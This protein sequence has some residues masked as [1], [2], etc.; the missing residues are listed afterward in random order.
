M[1]SG[2]G[3]LLLPPFRMACFISSRVTA[4]SS[5]GICVDGRDG[6]IASIMLCILSPCITNGPYL[7]FK[8]FAKA[9]TIPVGVWWTQPWSS[10]ICRM[11]RCVRFIY[12]VGCGIL[13]GVLQPFNR[14]RVCLTSLFVDEHCA[15]LLC[16]LLVDWVT[17]IF[18]REG[19]F[20]LLCHIYIRSSDFLIAR[21]LC[22]VLFLPVC[23]SVGFSFL[24]IAPNTY[25]LWD[26]IVWVGSSYTIGGVVCIW[27]RRLPLLPSSS[28]RFLCSVGTMVFPRS[29]ATPQPDGL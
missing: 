26:N 22:F 16:S 2:P 29:F 3:A 9:R 17:V 15:F 27:S 13:L 8:W 28:S 18:F 21:S 19:C 23:R 10:S 6:C 1:P 11:V 5:G 20:E 12:F 25:W 7:R 4:C 14:F 24:L